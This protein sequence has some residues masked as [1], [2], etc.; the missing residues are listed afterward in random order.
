MYKIQVQ[1]ANG[2]WHDVHAPDGTLLIFRGEREARAR[3]EELFAGQLKMERYA[4]PR[5]TRVIAVLRDEEEEDYHK[6]F[7]DCA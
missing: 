1:K 2:D 3:L 4:G 5:R 7:F 6:V